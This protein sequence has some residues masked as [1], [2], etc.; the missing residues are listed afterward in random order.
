MFSDEEDF[1]VPLNFSK[2]AKPVLKQP[3]AW[4]VDE[5]GRLFK[6]LNQSTK[7]VGGRKPTWFIGLQ[8]TCSEKEITTKEQLLA[9]LNT[10]AFMKANKDVMVFQMMKRE[11]VFEKEQKKSEMLKNGELLHS[12]KKPRKF[13]KKGILRFLS[14]MEAGIK[15]IKESLSLS[16][17]EEGEEEEGGEEEQQH[18]DT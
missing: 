5:C 18:T 6:L 16:D 17:E 15:K 2:Q 4:T 12:V 10:N 3:E 14:N 1:E 13:K 9:F 7:V 8:K 11:A